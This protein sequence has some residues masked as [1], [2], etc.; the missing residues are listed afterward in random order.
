M[1][2]YEEKLN[3]VKEKYLLNDKYKTLGEFPVGINWGYQFLVPLV[4]FTPQ[5]FIEYLIFNKLSI[6]WKKRYNW[7]SSTFKGLNMPY[8][9]QE[10]SNYA[11]IVNDDILKKYIKQNT[12]RALND[13]DFTNP[14][15]DDKSN[16]TLQEV[17]NEFSNFYPAEQP[18]SFHKFFRYCNIT[19][20]H[21]LIYMYNYMI[22]DLNFLNPIHFF[23]STDPINFNNQINLCLFF[24]SIDIDCIIYNNVTKRTNYKVNGRITQQVLNEIMEY[25]LG[26]AIS[27]DSINNDKKL[28]EILTR[29]SSTIVNTKSNK[30]SINQLLIRRDKVSMTCTYQMCESNF[31][32]PLRI[33]NAYDY[34]D[35]LINE[36]EPSHTIY[37]R[38]TNTDCDNVSPFHTKHGNSCYLLETNLRDALGTVGLGELALNHNVK[39][40]IKFYGTAFSCA[41]T[42]TQVLAENFIPIAYVKSGDADYCLSGYKIF[43]IKLDFDETPNGNKLRDK[44]SK[45]ITEMKVYASQAEAAEKNENAAIWN[46]FASVINLGK[47]IVSIVAGG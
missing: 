10:I 9:L 7:N 44:Y 47:E 18:H 8:V 17:L 23:M 31:R 36:K 34:I 24:L 45:L 35:S 2:K 41:P 26:F 28:L 16:Y 32:I 12:K 14:Y 5:R 11:F 19:S 37:N 1:N 46:A 40:S 13:T 38:V 3:K 25:G 29:K 20:L 21:Q 6:V 43:A 30:T 22:F 4:E 15:F 42:F 39:K 33:N 27:E